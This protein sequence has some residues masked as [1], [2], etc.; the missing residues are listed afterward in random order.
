MP[1]YQIDTLGDLDNP[2]L[3]MLGEVPE[4]IGVKYHRLAHGEVIAPDWPDDARI[5]MTEENPGIKLSSLLGNTQSFLLLHR[6]LKELVAAEYDRRGGKGKIE[7]LPFTLINHKGRP[8]SKDYFVVN[9]IGDFDCLN[10]KKS[11]ITYFKGNRDKV[12]S[13]D[14]LVLDPNKLRDAPPLFRVKQARGEYFVD[15]AL[16]QAIEKARFTNLLF[17]EVEA[18]PEARS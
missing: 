11:K 7:Y 2:K 6:D 1:Y 16:K 8:H 10:E 5:L 17:E 14:R 15:E 18:E 12:V 4:G 13:I 9:P 3:V